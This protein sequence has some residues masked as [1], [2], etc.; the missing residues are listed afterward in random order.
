MG[1][2]AVTKHVLEESPVL[3]VVD[4]LLSETF[5]VRI[6]NQRMD[7]SFSDIPALESVLAEIARWHEKQITNKE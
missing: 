4:S 6:R 7:I 3:I 5:E 1:V 2:I